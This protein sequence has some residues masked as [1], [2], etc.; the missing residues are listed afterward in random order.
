[1]IFRIW[2]SIKRWWKNHRWVNTVTNHVFPFSSFIF[3]LTP[4]EEAAAKKYK[5]EHKSRYFTYSF[6]PGEIGVC[7][8]ISCKDDK[9]GR[10]I[11]DYGSW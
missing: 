2:T 11:T 5:E 8:H 10:D 1:M 6:T 3:W 4:N 7:V 9:D